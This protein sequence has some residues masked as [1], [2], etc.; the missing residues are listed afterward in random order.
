MENAYDERN[1]KAIKAIETSKM[2][3]LERTITELEVC[4]QNS[5]HFYGPIVMMFV[6]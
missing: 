3:V 2:E 5:F 4:T 6:H 1:K